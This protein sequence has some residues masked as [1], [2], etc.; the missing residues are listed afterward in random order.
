[1]L[2]YDTVKDNVYHAYCMVVVTD[3]GS[4]TTSAPVCV[5]EWDATAGKGFE[6]QMEN[7]SMEEF[8]TKLENEGVHRR[9]IQGSKIFTYHALSGGKSSLLFAHSG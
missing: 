2:R 9:K 8:D 4:D 7:L 5:L 6:H 3:N 1:M